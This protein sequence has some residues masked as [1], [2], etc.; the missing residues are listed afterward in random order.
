LYIDDGAIYTIS[1]TLKAATESVCTKYKTVLTWLSENG[2]Q[3]DT[4]KIELITFTPK[5]ANP[6]FIGPPIHG[7]R[8]TL[9]IGDTYHV[10]TIKSL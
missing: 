4:T 3:T 10:S 5:R 9:L 1:I 8:Y 7:A 6:K 2:L